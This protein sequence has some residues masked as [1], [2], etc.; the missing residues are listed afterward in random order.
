V[1]RV[2]LHGLLPQVLP[3]VPSNHEPSPLNLLLKLHELPLLPILR[4]TLLDDLEGPD[5]FHTGMLVYFSLVKL[6]ELVLQLP[7]LLQ[8]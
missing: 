2:Y 1:S 5:D 7:F 4:V 3:G 8:S 6:L